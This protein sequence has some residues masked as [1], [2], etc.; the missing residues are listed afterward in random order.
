MSTKY[1]VE[2]HLVDEGDS[3]ALNAAAVNGVTFTVMQF[4]KSF[5]RPGI[6]IIGLDM[7]QEETTNGH[8]K[9]DV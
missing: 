4:S 6:T 9:G 1:P 7:V 3:Y 2:L 5:V 8:S